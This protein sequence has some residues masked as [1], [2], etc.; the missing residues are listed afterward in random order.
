MSAEAEKIG[1]KVMP[2]QFKNLVRKLS[3]RFNE[4]L[5]FAYPSNNKVLVY[6]STLSMDDVICSNYQLKCEIDSCQNLDKE[7]KDII[8]VAKIL[9]NEVK[10]MQP[11]M[12]WPPKEDDLKPNM[13]PK[14]IPHLLD[15]FC[16]VLFSGASM[17]SERK[18]N[19]K[20]V[21]LSN[22]ICQDIVYI[23]SNGNIKT[24]E[25]VLFPVV[26]KSLCNNT[27]VIRLINRHGHGISYDLI[28]E[29]ETEHALKVLNEQKEMRVVIPDEAMKC[30]NSPVR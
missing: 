26:V 19:E 28:E 25:S 23:V 6:P 3:N 5:K 29:I 17:E 2:S 20:V 27:E 13:V 4:E 7:S 9:N 10:A 16:T 24:T 1:V 12:S 11:Q 14:Y 21:R 18:K 22:S 8:K 30:D 15:M